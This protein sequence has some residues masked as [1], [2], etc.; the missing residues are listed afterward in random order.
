MKPK[1][2]YQDDAHIRDR[3]L[4]VISLVKLKC[5]SC[6]YYCVAWLTVVCIN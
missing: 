3:A 2:Y 5:M 1:E 6:A 4:T